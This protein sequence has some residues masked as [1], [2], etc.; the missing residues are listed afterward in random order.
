MYPLIQAS[1]L[2]GEDDRNPKNSNPGQNVGFIGSASEPQK[3]VRLDKGLG[4]IP[5]D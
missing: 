5:S 4:E 2:G 1:L 3:A